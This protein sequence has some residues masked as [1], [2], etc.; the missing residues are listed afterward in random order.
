[1]T[2]PTKRTCGT[3][4]VH[5]RLMATEPEYAANRVRIENHALEY[6]R[7][8]GLTGRTGITVI[9]VVVHVVYHNAAENI[10]DAQIN[11]Q[12]DVLNKDYRKTN[13]DI[14]KLPAVFAPLATDCRIEFQ[15]AT[16]DPSGNPTN[17]ITRTK[18]NKT[19]F[20]YD[21]TVKSGA[22]GGHDSW[23]CDKYLNIWVCPLGGGLLGYAQ[24]PGGPAATDGVVILHSAFGTTGTAAAPFNLGRTATH[25]IGHFLNLYHIWGDER[26]DQDP[27]SLSDFVGDTPNQA[28]PN[29]QKPT[30]PHVTCS[31]GPNGDLFMNYMDYVD[32]D[33]MFMF[34][35]GQ[36]T[37]MHACLDSDRASL[38]FQKN[39]INPKIIKDFSDSKGTKDIRDIKWKDIIDIKVQDQM[40]NIKEVKEKEFKEVQE[41][42]K[43]QESLPTLPQV[44]LEGRVVQLEQVVTALT[45]FIGSEQRPDLQTSALS[46]EADLQALSQQLAQQAVDAKA[47]KDNKDVEKLREV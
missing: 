23:P 13:A 37:R 16:K 45:H 9:P 33:T 19:S 29:Y 21:D 7:T 3:Q 24:F 38:G 40:K 27:C 8:R 15:L 10:S 34:T 22:S 31:N 5:N 35:A 39:V 12:I 25:E 44:S 4:D 26:P 41:G 43:L 11:S 30:F 18:T 46:Q 2:T 42:P 17:G 36:V 1:M 20:G 28:G 32:D 14:P 6:A 47:A